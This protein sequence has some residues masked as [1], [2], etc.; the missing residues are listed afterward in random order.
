[1]NAQSAIIIVHF[2]PLLTLQQP[3]EKFNASSCFFF[4][5]LIESIRTVKK[6]GSFEERLH[7]M[8]FCPPLVKNV[9]IPYIIKLPV[10]MFH[11]DS[12]NGWKTQ[13]LSNDVFKNNSIYWFE[14]NLFTEFHPMLKRFGLSEITNVQIA[15]WI[16]N[17]STKLMKY[18]KNGNP[19]QLIK[20]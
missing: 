3:M 16:W 15:R 9:H 19:S 10:E 6:S 12:G 2:H 14:S 17:I 1:M 7:E 4:N 13:N 5:I 8:P 11:Y 20:F 18:L